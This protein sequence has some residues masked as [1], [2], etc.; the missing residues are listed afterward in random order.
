MGRKKWILGALIILLAAAV[1]AFVF[2]DILTVIFAPKLALSA[3]VSD[4]LEK[5]E[6]RFDDSPLWIL[7][8]GVDEEGRNTTQ[9]S[10]STTDSLL[11]TINYDMTI[12]SDWTRNQILA[13]G[14]VS[15]ENSDLNLSVYLDRE[16][17]AITSAEL[18][19]GGWY[20]I[21]Y[22]TFSEDLQSIPLVSL[23]VPDNTVSQWEEDV[24][25]LQTFMN[26][27]HKL[28]ELP[29]LSQEDVRALL[30]GI[31]GL[32]SSVQRENCNINGQ[33]LACWRISYHAEGKKVEN[34]LSYIIEGDTSGG[35][36]NGVFYLYEN[37]LV[38]LLLGGRAG[39]QGITCSLVLGLDASKDPLQ[40]EMVNNNGEDVT[41]LDAM[42]QAA[43]DG[44][45]RMGS[46]QLN[47]STVSY[48]WNSDS[49]D[50]LLTLPTTGDIRMTLSPAENG[51]QIITNDLS[52]IL[53]SDSN[54]IGECVM[55]VG[56]GADIAVPEYKNLDTWSMNDLLVLLGG[57]GSMIGLTDN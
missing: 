48:T 5:L 17:A 10:L 49:G 2:W 32:K 8:E 43:G 9:M 34:L 15:P 33:D 55:T 11:G 25:A 56:K 6:N 57:I 50:L 13:Q 16:F 47:N 23:L 30:L 54:T 37:T 39:E 4:G 24:S 7:A 22:D 1:A 42:I 12:F 36:L 3:A 19:Q 20:G 27:S 35:E 45:E 38:K 18:L 40:F 28:P 21:T 26:Q 51:F 14:T 31:L 53:G 44:N 46:I 41:N 52:K 29:E